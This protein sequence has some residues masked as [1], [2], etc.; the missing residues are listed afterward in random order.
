MSLYRDPKS[1]YWW[2]RITAPD[3]RQIRHSTRTADKREAQEQHDHLKSDLWRAQP[4]VEK[5]WL[6][7][8]VSWLEAGDRGDSDRYMLR[9]LKIED[10]PLSKITPDIIS[11]ALAGEKP[12]TW[13]RKKNLIMAILNHAASLGWLDRAPKVKSK[14]E[15]EGRILWLTASE[16]QALYKELPDHLKPICKLAITTG[17]RQHNILSL[18]WREV[19]MKRRVLWV[20]PDEAKAGKPISIPI[21][22]EA[23][24]VLQSQAG[25]N[26]TWVFPYSNKR[27][28]ADL[29]KCGPMS[30][31]GEAF[32]RACVRAGLYIK[33]VRRKDRYGKSSI[34]KRS[35]FVFHC[36]RHTW[37]SW[38]VMN[39]TPLEVL[40]KLGGWASLDMVQ[41]YAHLAPGHVA[42]FAGNATPYDQGQEKVA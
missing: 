15:P 34:T 38:H 31:I 22:D 36:L 30:E 21:N 32:D 20:H 16:W 35:G 10:L 25:K 23:L 18:A 41:K 1:P 33:E 39:G 7:A 27:K 28:D 6:E 4:G 13:N 40:Q 2:I 17:M 14:K 5:S 12:G 9:N 37:A 11:E 26:K 42:R 3:G 24:A 19:D 8:C 29:S